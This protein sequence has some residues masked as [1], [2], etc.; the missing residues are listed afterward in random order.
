MNP[1]VS[2]WLRL[3]NEDLR[4]AERALQDEIFR[5]VC[6]HAQQAVEKALKGLLVARVG[7]HIKGHSLEQLLLSDPGVGSELAMWR[8]AL[9]KLDQFYLPTRY[10]DVVPTEAAEPTRAD[11]ESAL[12]DATAFGADIR[13]KLDRE[14]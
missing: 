7:T 6:F 2:R 5:Q 9:R 8:P 13:S 14:R 4:M 10:A 12:Q 1:L 3:A 11:A